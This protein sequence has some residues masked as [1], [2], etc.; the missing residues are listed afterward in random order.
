MSVCL[1]V[2]S[3]DNETKSASQTTVGKNCGKEQVIRPK[4]ADK[5]K[6][7]L[8]RTRQQLICRIFARVHFETFGTVSVLLKWQNYNKLSCIFSVVLFS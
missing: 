6:L 8:Q 2:S 4:A 7:C 3:Y 1:S 5:S